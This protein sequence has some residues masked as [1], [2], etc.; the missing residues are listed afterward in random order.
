[1]CSKDCYDEPDD[2]EGRVIGVFGGSD[3]RKFRLEYKNYKLVVLIIVFDY[4]P[5]VV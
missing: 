5:W 1:M 3:D 4:N 2:R